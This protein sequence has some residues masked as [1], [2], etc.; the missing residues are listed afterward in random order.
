MDVFLSARVIRTMKEEEEE[1]E[2]EEEREKHEHSFGLDSCTRLFNRRL[3]DGG[4]ILQYFC[5][6]E[7]FDGLI[8]R[9]LLLNRNL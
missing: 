4:L 3:A 5:Y 6:A 9:N 8:C 2:E 7:I 1:N